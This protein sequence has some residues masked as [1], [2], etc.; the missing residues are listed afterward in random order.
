MSRARLERVWRALAFVLGHPLNRGRPLRA[1]ARV[2][3]WQLGSRLLPGAVAVPF[4]GATRLLV[5]PGMTGATGNVYC[6]L[7]EFEHM[8]FALH[9]LRA[10][11]LFVDVGANVGTYTVLAAGAC[12]AH[13]LAIEPEPAT[14][15]ALRDNLRLNAL[16]A[17]VRVVS[18]ALGASPGRVRLS[19]QLGPMNHVLDGTTAARDHGCDVPMTTLDVLLGAQAAHLLKIDVEGYEAAVLAGAEHTLASPSARAAIL[20]ANGSGARYASDEQA[21]HASML[22]HG[23][24]PCRYDPLTRAL[25]A[26][27]HPGASGNVLYV[28]DPSAMQARV[29]AAPRYRVLECDL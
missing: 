23:F 24:A 17:R 5:R 8:G 3:R 26:D 22:A 10:D 28:R 15:A 12:G 14:C 6:G 19:T 29:R 4:V 16:E 2:L 25:T 9:A 21:V 1:L 11:E 27:T 18:A 20:E 7:H 13:V